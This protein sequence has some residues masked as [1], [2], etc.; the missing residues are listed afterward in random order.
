[1][2]K[3]ALI[4]VS[5]GTSH[6]RA[7]KA[8]ENIERVCEEA[9]PEYD[10]F[11]AF[12]SGMIIR[13][14]ARTRNM[15]ILN[16]S[17]IMEK[18]SRQGYEEVICQ[19]TN[20]INGLEYEKL[21]GMLQPYRARIPVIR[22]G[23]PLLTD[24]RDYR[25]TAKIVM[26]QLPEPLGPDQAFVLMGHGTDHYVNASYS[27]FDMMLHYLDHFDTFVGT[28][29]GFPGLDFV[30]KRL[31]RAGKKQVTIMPLMIVAGDH[32]VNDMAG[33][34]EDS[35]KSVLEREGFET[36]LIIKGLGEIDAIG[37]LFVEHIKEADR[38]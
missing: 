2:G 26:D 15:T 17:E 9:F 10:F 29:E 30:V 37:R 14:L 4:V 35:W 31:K 32:A 8:I 24:L 20:I 7:I 34:D 11:R 19:P 38:L 27:Q 16:P 23:K 21:I 12:T 18:L 13:K 33:E 25:E 36:R 6:E 1:M 3:K 5:F 22:I 28:V